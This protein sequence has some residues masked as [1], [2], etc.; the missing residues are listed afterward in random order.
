MKKIVSSLL[1]LCM[2]MALTACGGKEQTVSY[3]TT[4][5]QSGL[6]MVDTMTLD[7]KGDKVQK[8]TEVIEMDM[9]AFDADQQA[10]MAE[11]YDALIEQYNA[12]DGVECTGEAGDG[13]YTMNIVVDTTGD[14]VSQLADAGLMEVE[15]NADGIS[16]K[17]TGESLEAS[18]YTLVE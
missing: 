17:R 4:Q 6:V 18:G 13:T 5:E 16:L 1:V 12:I 15:G 2:V 9:S 7:A 3:Q 14:A 10:M 11:M 8:L